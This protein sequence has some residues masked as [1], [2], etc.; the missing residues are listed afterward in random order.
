MYPLC[1]VMYYYV[2]HAFPSSVNSVA[3]SNNCEA[4]EINLVLSKKNTQWIHL[5]TLYF[6]IRP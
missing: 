6:R 2:L 5:A 1:I 4:K 3:N